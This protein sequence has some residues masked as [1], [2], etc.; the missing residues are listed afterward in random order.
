MLELWG[1]NNQMKV[2]WGGHHKLGLS[3]K[4]VGI[5][6]NIQGEDFQTGSSKQKYKNEVLR[7]DERS[8]QWLDYSERMRNRALWNW[9]YWIIVRDY[10][11]INLLN[12][13]LEIITHPHRLKRTGAWP[14]CASVY[15]A[16]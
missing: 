13:K 4:K 10:N 6:G 7:V 2:P 1:E 15:T 14:L 12:Y 3:E 16:N 5:T 9:V 11:T 8:N